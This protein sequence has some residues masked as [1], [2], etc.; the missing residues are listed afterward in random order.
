MRFKDGS[1]LVMK[2]KDV[3]PSAL[4]AI[5]DA[6]VLDIALHAEALALF[7]KRFREAEAAGKLTVLPPPEEGG[8]ARSLMHR[9][10]AALT[11]VGRKE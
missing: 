3:P 11:D 7:D 4:S 8:I 9:A 2:R 6:N 10:G 1:S 5:A